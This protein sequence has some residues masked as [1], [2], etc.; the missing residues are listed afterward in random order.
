VQGT[1]QRKK[2]CRESD[3]L[4]KSWQWLSRGNWPLWKGE[5]WNT[6]P[7]VQSE[8]K[9]HDPLRLMLRDSGRQETSLWLLTSVTYRAVPLLYRSTDFSVVITVTTIV[10]SWQP[11]RM[12]LVW[13]MVPSREWGL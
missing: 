4:Q 1:A 8:F 12:G 13:D 10:I 2:E 6:W 3:A 9:W 5:V 11:S 7:S